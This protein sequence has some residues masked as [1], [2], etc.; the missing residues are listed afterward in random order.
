MNNNVVAKIQKYCIHRW[1]GNGMDV[2][3]EAI[4]IAL[5]RYQSIENVNFSLFK[6]LAMEAA[7]NLR[8][9]ETK[10]D[11]ENCIITPRSEKTQRRCSEYFA[12]ADTEDPMEWL[13]E[14]I[15]QEIIKKIKQMKVHG[16]TD[17]EIVQILQPQAME[18][19][20]KYIS[21]S[22]DARKNPIQE[23]LL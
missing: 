19:K 20:K 5:E 3:Q 13:D 4:V 10:Q 17:N 18:I 15:K 22:S 7:R 1:N 11:E 21:D 14:K 8:V 2:F 9:Q 6:L 12:L 23:R 16:Y